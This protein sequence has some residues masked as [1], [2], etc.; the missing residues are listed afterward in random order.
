MLELEAGV[1]PILLSMTAFDS[2]ANRSFAGDQHFS[3]MRTALYGL[4]PVL[5]PF[6][7]SLWKCQAFLQHGAGLDT[8]TVIHRPSFLTRDVSF[9][10]PFEACY[11]VITRVARR[12]FDLPVHSRCGCHS[13]LGVGTFLTQRS[14][15]RSLLE[16]IS[17]LRTPAVAVT[18]PPAC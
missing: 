15:Q 18:P 11:P 5:G 4:H 8:E 17:D 13:L 14:P 3:E 12:P 9:L 1:S 2:A 16:Q 6:Q 7:C 10:L